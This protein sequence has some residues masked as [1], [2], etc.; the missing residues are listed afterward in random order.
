MGERRK[1]VGCREFFIET[2]TGTRTGTGKRHSRLA[3]RWMSN[4]TVERGGAVKKKLV[5][6]TS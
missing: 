2:E 1:K 4:C 6:L 3:M 5:K